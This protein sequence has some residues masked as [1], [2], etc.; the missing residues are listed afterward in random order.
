MVVQRENNVLV[1]QRDRLDEFT[2]SVTAW[3]MVWGTFNS[4]LRNHFRPETAP[5]PAAAG[6]EE[7][8]AG[9]PLEPIIPEVVPSFAQYVPEPPSA[10]IKTEQ[11]QPAPER[12]EHR[13][14]P[15]DKIPPTPFL[16]WEK[17]ETYAPVVFA[18]IAVVIIVLGL[19]FFL[20]LEYGR[21]GKVA[22]VYAVFLILWSA[23]LWY[24]KKERYAVFGRSLIACGWAGIYLTTF[25]IHY[26]P[27]AREITNPTVGMILLTLIAGGMI[28][29]SFRY[30]SQSLTTL[31]YSVA[32]ATVSLSAHLSDE[33]FFSLIATAILSVSMLFILARL[34][35]VWLAYASIV[36]S[37]LSLFIWLRPLMSSFEMR[38]GLGAEFWPGLMM[39]VLYWLTFTAAVSL[40]KP[41]PEGKEKHALGMTATNF[42]LFFFLS[43]YICG[44]EHVGLRSYITESLTMAYVA[45]IFLAHLQKRMN[46]YTLNLVIAS[47]SCTMSLYY[48]LDKGNWVA[49]GW[50]LQ[51]EALYI[52]GLLM[53]DTRYRTVGGL[54]FV[55]VGVWLLSVDYNLADK[56]SLFG[57][58][59]YK[60][61]IMYMTASIVFYLNTIVRYALDYRIS[62]EDNN[63][64]LFSYGA[65]ILWLILMIRN[66][67]P[68]YL[69]NAAV[70]G[71]FLGMLLVETG[72]RMQ[73]QNIRIQ[74]LFFSFIGM[75]AALVPLT[76]MESSY[77]A[78]NVRFRIGCE[79]AVVIFTYVAF[80][81][82]QKQLLRSE[83]RSNL[84]MAV[85][86]LASVGCVVAVMLFY[87]E[88]ILAYPV[89]I[90]SAWIILAVLLVELGVTFDNPFFRAQGYVVAALAAVW[91]L[92][93]LFDTSIR[94]DF[95][96]T[97]LFADLLVVVGFIYLFIRVLNVTA[98]NAHSLSEI[99]RAEV[100]G[101]YGPWPLV[102]F[103][104]AAS[105]ILAVLLLKVLAWVTPVLV[106]AAWIFVGI[107]I[108][109]AGIGLG[110][111]LLR[112]L[113]L[114]L[115]FAAFVYV[116]FHVLFEW[117][118]DGFV[119]S[120][121]IAFLA[122]VA[123]L[124]YICGRSSAGER[125]AAG[126]TASSGATS[127]FSWL[128]AILLAFLI[129]REMWRYYPA[130]V[131]LAWTVQMLVLFWRGIVSRDRDFLG[132]SV[133]LSA[134]IFFWTAMVNTT[135]FFW[136]IETHV[137]VEQ[138][139]LL[140][141]IPIVVLFYSLTAFLIYRGVDFWGAG[142]SN[143]LHYTREM[144]SWWA[145]AILVLLITS[146]MAPTYSIYTAA[147]WIVVAIALFEI[148]KGARFS[149]L[150]IQG[151]VLAVGT[152]I[153]VIFV[154]ALNPGRA[155]LMI[156]ERTISMV[157]VAL[158]L[159]YLCLRLRKTGED[160]V[161]EALNARIGSLMSYLGTII[162]L[163]TSE[164]APIH[165]IYVAPVWIVI[166]IALFE[167]G[168]RVEFSSLVTQG[169]VLAAIAFA[170]TIFVDPYNPGQAVLMTDERTIAMVAVALGLYY[171]W[172]RLRK[173]GEDE[174]EEA[175]NA[176]MGSLMSY[177]GTTILM[178]LMYVAMEPTARFPWVPAGWSGLLV[179]VM[180]LGIVFTDARM[181]YQSMVMLIPVAFGILAISFPEH[182]TLLGRETNGVAIGGLLVARVLWQLGVYNRKAH[183]VKE[184]VAPRLLLTYGRHFY[185][186]PA[187][188]LLGV[189][190][191]LDL[192][193][194]LVR[195]QPL[196]WG[197]EGLLL[198]AMGFAMTD[199]VLRITGLVALALA[200]IRVFH[201]LWTTNIEMKYRVLALVGLGVILLVT[202]W[203]YSRFRER[204]NK[205][206]L[207]E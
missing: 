62:K 179:L 101:G 108:L 60:R 206:L 58:E 36:G 12:I 49:I 27:S 134:V 72:I 130:W 105:L 180:L 205:V 192:S 32:F 172:L 183:F 15:P 21:A 140:S 123:G 190:I 94:A 77:F 100:P 31:T 155:V 2:W 85:A 170:R 79:V 145:S 3:F 41:D 197:L 14:K 4:D 61:T 142:L 137:A 117:G 133:V 80:G 29:H 30:R 82:F 116:G 163:I 42:A 75:F 46:L 166:A 6:P 131:A 200:V 174:V 196:G 156:D 107:A 89:Y 16:D 201:D 184:G 10:V 114:A 124:Y 5:T 48:L 173:S 81:R 204:I 177:Q 84:E 203:L 115:G 35:W 148:G 104:I 54:N 18:W 7:P 195:Y 37:Y 78:E 59:I 122:C 26:L 64:F 125:D 83:Q 194:I 39:L 76:Y 93:F 13:I 51:A 175:F 169:W 38:G 1:V 69:L 158:G 102:F 11:V 112:A 20:S 106:G 17:V 138:Y 33:R 44:P 22:S 119:T 207:S 152:F 113:A 150:V 154:N 63:S 74:G 109:E 25:L 103:P 52:A 43:R 92:H 187:A 167:I 56:V 161:E 159:Y 149:P 34:Q 68:G 157:V 136:N 182:G 96:S 178:L 95:R 147:A 199:R 146:E 164:L 135:G 45:L 19:G 99:E 73:D 88:F 90:A 143:L 111:R 87:R 53:D 151:C 186:I 9:V 198:I 71:A 176:R 55:L 120:R 70:A 97:I 181:I 65:S 168:R 191:P 47:L 50:L 126:W 160:E 57:Y 185:S 162:L 132:Q 171:L 66:W 202:A 129:E 91:A 139:R 165:D 98:A 110:S 24:E 141:V 28:A 23:G 67:F 127:F 144:L 193:G 188:V 8:V 118:L 128:A 189:F 86:M 40:L 153:R 121:F